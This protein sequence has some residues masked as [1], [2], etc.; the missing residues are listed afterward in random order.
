MLSQIKYNLDGNAIYYS[1]CNADTD[2]SSTQILIVD[3]LGVLAYLY[4]YGKWAYVGGGFTPY[5]HSIIEATVYGLPVAFG[6]MIHRK[7]TPHQLIELGIGNI[8]R[9]ASD[10]QKWFETIKDNPNKIK[11]I[12]DIALNYTQNNSGATSVIVNLLEK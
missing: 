3:C 12:K 4:R 8:V 10:I 7:V 11:E 1:E 6:P 9:S 2:F 5:L